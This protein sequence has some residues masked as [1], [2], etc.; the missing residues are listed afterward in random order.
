MKFELTINGGKSFHFGE[1]LKPEIA[2]EFILDTGFRHQ[3][4]Y[5][6]IKSNNCTE[7]CEI[8][9]H[10]EPLFQYFNHYSSTDVGE[11][12]IKK[13]DSTTLMNSDAQSLFVQAVW[14]I[15]SHSNCGVFGIRGHLLRHYVVSND[16]DSIAYALFSTFL[17]D[18]NMKQDLPELMGQFLEILFCYKKFF[19]NLLRNARPKSKTDSSSNG[20]VLL[21]TFI[22]L[23]FLHFRDIE[24]QLRRPYMKP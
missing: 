2:S 6:I 13:E 12:K 24:T 15:L 1:N 17:I 19:D 18:A 3:P 10:L 20:L 7:S 9:Y 5:G 22:E 14:L 23:I 4:C 11:I 21:E 16:V 8:L